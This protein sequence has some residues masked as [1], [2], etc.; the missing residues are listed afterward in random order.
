VIDG[1]PTTSW[2]TYAYKQQFPA[3]KPGI[4]LMVS[5]ASAVQLSSLSIDSPSAGT[6]VQIRSAPT[7]DAAFG[8]TVLVTQAT[9]RSG[10][11]QISLAQSQ[12]VQHL[13]IWVTKLGGDNGDN[14]TEINEVRFQRAGD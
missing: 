6:V 3:L 12:P 9:L 5:F 1:D 14:V 2:R 8:D 13:L 4:G 11:T 10:T 7:A